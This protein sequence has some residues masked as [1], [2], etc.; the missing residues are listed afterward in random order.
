MVWLIMFARHSSRRN[1][2]GVES[3]VRS[4]GLEVNGCESISGR[5]QPPLANYFVNLL[6]GIV[7]CDASSDE[8]LH[9][10]GNVDLHLLCS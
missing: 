8:F 2:I 4:M 6:D 5:T 3:Y 7:P 1:A 9:S 10:R